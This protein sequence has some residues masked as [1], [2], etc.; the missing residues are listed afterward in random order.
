MTQLDTIR[1]RVRSRLAGRADLLYPES[2]TWSD[3]TVCRFKVQDPAKDGRSGPQHL[4]T[5]PLDASLRRLKIYPDDPSPALGSS[6][7]YQGGTLVLGAWTDES[8]FTGTNTGLC[9]LVDRRAYPV[10]AVS[11]L[12]V[13]LRLLILARTGNAVVAGAGA[14]DVRAD[15]GISHTAHTPPGVVLQ[16]GDELV[17]QAATATRSCRRYNGTFSVTRW[18]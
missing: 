8:R 4:T 7:S 11:K 15:L 9:R 6:V 17:P 14:Q 2:A 13:R 5:D 10:L 12:G 3:A 1:T 16:V 18:A